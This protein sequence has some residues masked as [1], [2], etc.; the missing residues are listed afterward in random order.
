MHSVDIVIIGC[1]PVGALLIELGA[2]VS[3]R[4]HHQVS[5]L[6]RLHAMHHSPQRL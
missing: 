2:Y 3:H 4:L 6:W 1:G 5:L